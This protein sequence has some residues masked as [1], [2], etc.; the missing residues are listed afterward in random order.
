MS[1]AHVL[2]SAPS[3]YVY[4]M[5]TQKQ[6][7][8]RRL[9]SGLSSEEDGQ[10]HDKTVTGIPVRYHQVPVDAIR[11]SAACACACAWCDVVEILT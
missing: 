9:S 2:R 3:L 1:I 7:D 4:L 10:T 8:T 6:I 5:I 11:R